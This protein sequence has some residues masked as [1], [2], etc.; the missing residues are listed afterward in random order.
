[1]PVVLATLEAEAGELLESS[2][3]RGYTVS[4]RLVLNSLAQVIHLPWPSENARI[5]EVSHR[6][7]CKCLLKSDTRIRGGAGAQAGAAGC[8]RPEFRGKP[9]RALGGAP[10]GVGVRD[11]ESAVPSH[12]ETWPEDGGHRGTEAPK[13]KPHG[14]KGRG[15]GC[16]A[17]GPQGPAAPRR[18][19]RRCGLGGGGPVVPSP[20]GDV[21]EAREPEARRGEGQNRTENHQQAASSEPISKGSKSDRWSQNGSS[22]K[23][24]PSALRGDAALS[25]EQATG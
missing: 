12:K 18:P 23:G 15:G 11:G 8:A 10:R 25:Q 5:T 21:A 14:I 3:D 16:T 22:A 17:L 7:R 19:V 13:D 6:A 2:R 24:T 20:Q 9:G 4:P 1:M